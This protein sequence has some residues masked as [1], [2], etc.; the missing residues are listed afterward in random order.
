MEKMTQG[1]KGRK[2]FICCVNCNKEKKTNLR[3]VNLVFP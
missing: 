2:V 1:W 3:A